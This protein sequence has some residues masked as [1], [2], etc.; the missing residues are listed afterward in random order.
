MINLIFDLNNI[1]FRSLFTVSGYGKNSFTFNTDAEVQQLVRK[2]AMDIAYIIRLINPSRIIFAQDSKSW[3]K[4]IPIDENEGYKAQRVKSGVINWE[5]IYNAL[6][7]FTEIMQNDGMILTKIES[8]EADD[9]CALWSHELQFNQNQHVVIV[10]G[11]EDMRQ[12]V[13]FHPY[14]APNKKFAFCTVFNPFMQG[15]NASRKLFIPD[16][17]E[18]WITTF[19][20][21]DFMNMKATMNV[22]KD[23]FKKIITSERTKIE[24]INGRMV[25]L[26]KIFCGDDGDNVPAIYSWLNEKGVEVRVT[27]TKFEKIYEMLLTS[28]IELM[29]HY[30]LLKRSSKVMEAL[31]MVTKQNPPFEIYSRLVRQIKLVILDSHFFP[32]ELV[33]QFNKIKENELAKSKVNYSSINMK[34]LLEGTRYV[35]EKKSKNEAS[36]FKEID[37]INHT[38]LF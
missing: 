23:D 7:E 32:T 10:S 1:C 20:D 35:T 17:F 2:M 27:N 12:L 29:D 31:K 3:R 30:D 24:H 33:E 14:D 19:D 25:G 34:N 22:D 4:S 21:V 37:R 11:D 15:K 18:E 5:N 26:R 38:S 36:I 13:H 6:D 9:I 28:P 8:L 16:Y